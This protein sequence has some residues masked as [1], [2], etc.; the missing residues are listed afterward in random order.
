M[1]GEPSRKR[2]R[3]DPITVG[4]SQTFDKLLELVGTG[5]ANI[6]TAT[7]IARTVEADFALPPSSGLVKLAKCG[8]HGACSQNDERDF[9]RLVKGAYGMNL[10]PYT[11][12]V[13]LEA[14][15]LCLC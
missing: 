7:E 9:R 6:S 13:T 5:G 14:S 4:K 2:Q 15:Q 3:A 12:K 11:I 1:P 8:A 10:E